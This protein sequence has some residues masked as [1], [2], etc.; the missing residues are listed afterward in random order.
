MKDEAE[1]REWMDWASSECEKGLEDNIPFI[2][3]SKPL[4]PQNLH[5][6]VS[7][8]PITSLRVIRLQSRSNNLIR[9]SYATS[10][11]F[12][13]CAASQ[14]IPVTQLPSV[15]FRSLH[16]MVLELLVGHELHRSMTDT[17]Q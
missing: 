8:R 11:G 9:I 13:Q 5:Q 1:Q 15:A 12:G 17:E 14:V 6:N 4:M 2:K 3:S 10:K 16:A 7:G